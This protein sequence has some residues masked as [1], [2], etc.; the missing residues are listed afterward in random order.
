MKILQP[1]I[2][3]QSKIQQTSS[4]EQLETLTTSR[5]GSTL[6]CV[7][8]FVNALSFLVK[9]EMSGE[10]PDLE[11]INHF[12]LGKKI[13]EELKQKYAKQQEEEKKVATAIHLL[14]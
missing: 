8:H 2:S 10:A 6:I 13:L 5:S 4:S 9:K 3:S 7:S 1:R 11:T 12:S 14:I